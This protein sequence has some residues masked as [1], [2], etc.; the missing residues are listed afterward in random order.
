MSSNTLGCW[1]RIASFITISTP[2]WKIMPLFPAYVIF[3]HGV[4]KTMY[5]LNS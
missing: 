2:Q 4:T 1:Q 3:R 5:V